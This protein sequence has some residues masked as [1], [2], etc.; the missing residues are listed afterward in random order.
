MAMTRHSPSGLVQPWSEIEMSKPSDIDTLLKADPSPFVARQ[1][2][3]WAASM[4]NRIARGDMMLGI[5]TI[6]EVL[7]IPMAYRAAA[8]HGDPAAWVALAWWHANPQI[9]EPDLD[10]A[11]EALKSAND[12]KVSNARLELAKIR[13]YFKRDTATAREMEEAYHFV[14]SAVEAKP[15]NA[16]AVYLLALLTTHGFGVAASPRA[17]FELQR[18]AADLGNADAMFELS[19]HYAHG[20]GVGASETAALD[21]C[22]RAAEAG[23]SRAI[24]NLGAFH[25]TGR[26]MAKNIPEAVKWYELAAEAGN[27]SAMVGLAAILASGDGVEP[28]RE[29]A[30]QLLDQ[31]EYCGLDVSHVREQLGL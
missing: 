28:D 22:R 12:A 5:L 4:R 15:E 27:P 10:T 7:K 16:E 9:G 1:L 23:H 17:G 29:Y 30:S 8:L 21:A 6:D 26:G 13:W 2:V 18:R 14:S 20:L 19:L 31:A 24:Y 3:E 25:A 11:E